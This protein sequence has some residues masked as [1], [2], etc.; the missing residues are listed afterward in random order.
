MVFLQSLKELV[1]FPLNTIG[2]HIELSLDHID[3]FRL[4]ATFFEEL[5]YSRSDEVQ[6][7][8]LALPDIQNDGAV[9]AVRAAHCV[10]DFVHLESPKY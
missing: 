3:Y 7:E 10:G 2:A 9:L 8:H 1:Y 5:E 4:R 6:V